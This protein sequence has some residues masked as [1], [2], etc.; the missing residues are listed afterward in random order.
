[1]KMLLSGMKRIYFAII[2]L[3]LMIGIGIEGY[4]QLEG[5]TFVEALF[6]TVIT[7]STVGFREVHELSPAGMIFTTLLIVFSFG[8]FAYVITTLTKYILDGEFR[9]QFKHYQMI[10]RISKAHNHIIVCGFGRNGKQ[11]TL[12]LL[13]HG[14]QVIVIEQNEDFLSDEINEKIIRNPRFIYVHGDAVQ[15]TSLIR[16]QIEKAK[17]LITTLP[18]D[19][20][21]LFV[22]LTAREMND[23]LT[24]ISRATADHTDTKLKR[25]GADNVIMPDRV[26]GARMA[27]L[28]IQPNI[29]EF[30]EQLLNPSSELVNI[31]EISCSEL[32]ACML[33]RTIDELE[34]RKKSGA[35]LIG[36]KLANNEYIFNPAPDIQI[37]IDDKL[38]VLGTNKQID[39]L[40]KVLND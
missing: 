25:A 35:N 36:L 3:F 39:K 6:M 33:N 1:M 15:E 32:N 10:K 13:S 16:A 17:A 2:S 21:N 19:A 29:V 9:N 7:I 34:I 14:E 37:K 5:F 26:G 20:D 31:E 28:V 24:I 27:K 30:V 4:M 11:V 12:D 23:H 40:K 8:I 22:V 18:S 38:F